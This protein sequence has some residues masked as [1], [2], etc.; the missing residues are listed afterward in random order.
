MLHQAFLISFKRKKPLDF[1]DIPPDILIH[2]TVSPRNLVLSL[3]PTPQKNIL[4]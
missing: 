1:Q 2:S 3:A 4:T